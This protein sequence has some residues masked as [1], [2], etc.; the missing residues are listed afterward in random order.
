MMALQRLSND[1][2]DKTTPAIE[3]K[4]ETSGRGRGRGTFAASLKRRRGGL[5]AGKSNSLENKCIAVVH[6]EDHAD[7]LWSETMLSNLLHCGIVAEEK[8]KRK[9]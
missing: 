2:L 3:A 9:K 8:Q 6:N 1:M 4:R 7:R 5:S